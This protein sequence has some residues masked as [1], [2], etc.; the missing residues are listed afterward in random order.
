[1]HLVALTATQGANS[2]QQQQLVLL[3][4]LLLLL[5]VLLEKLLVLPMLPVLPV[6]LLPYLLL[7]LLLLPTRQS[8]LCPCCPDRLTPG[9]G[10]PLAELPLPPQLG[11]ALLAA[12][13]RFGC[14]QELLTLSGMLSVPSV[15]AAPGAY[16][17]CV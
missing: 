7:L 12:A 3:L 17:L 6:L 13:N 15:W 10:V 2:C 4:L 1:M 8:M 16:V 11:A 5:P 14:C 9:V